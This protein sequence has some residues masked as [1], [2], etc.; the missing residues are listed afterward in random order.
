[1]HPLESRKERIEFFRKRDWT[2][3]IIGPKIERKETRERERERKNGKQKVGRKKKPNGRVNTRERER[4][5][6]TV[7]RG[8]NTD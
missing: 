6:G 7:S 5:N 2:K 4:K 1:M 3:I 8:R